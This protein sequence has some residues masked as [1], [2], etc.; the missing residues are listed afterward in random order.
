MDL[1]CGESVCVLNE[2]S[3]VLFFLGGGL[4]PEVDSSPTFIHR[5]KGDDVEQ[6]NDND[7]K[8]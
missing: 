7:M 1:G 4:Q 8:S 2:C 6:S 5:G 3:L